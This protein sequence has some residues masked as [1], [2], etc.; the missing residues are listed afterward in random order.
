M[1]SGASWSEV[2]S[3]LNQRVNK[4]QQ[5]G[6]GQY[7]YDDLYQSAQNYISQQ[8]QREQ[9]EA[10]IWLEDMIAAQKR[11]A[12]AQ[13]NNAYQQNVNARCV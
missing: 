9:E 8:K 7:M 6:Y 5:N 12:I 1:N 3:L 4:T 10:N 2:Q 13:I 11:A